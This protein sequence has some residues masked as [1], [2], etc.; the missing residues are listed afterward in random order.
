MLIVMDFTTI[1][2]TVFKRNYVYLRLL[3][4]NRKNFLYNPIQ[5]FKTE[6]VFS[7]LSA[8]TGYNIFWRVMRN[9][10]GHVA[11]ESVIQRLAKQLIIR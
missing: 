9:C 6:Q 11:T 2:E 1:Y 5:R 8:F 3:S 7:A 10:R 4:K